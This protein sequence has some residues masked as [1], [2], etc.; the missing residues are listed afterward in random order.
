MKSNISVEFIGDN[1]L[2]YEGDAVGL[3]SKLQVINPGK[4]THSN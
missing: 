4:I 3:V 1:Q 2:T